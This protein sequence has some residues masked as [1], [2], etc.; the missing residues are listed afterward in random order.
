MGSQETALR[1]HEFRKEEGCPIIPPYGSIP[2]GDLPPNL[3]FVAM[4]A[5]PWRVC[6][7]MAAANCDEMLSAASVAVDPEG[8]ERIVRGAIS[9]ATNETKTTAYIDDGLLSEIA[10]DTES[11]QPVI[12]E[13]GSPLDLPLVFASASLRG[14]GFVPLNLDNTGRIKFAGF[15]DDPVNETMVRAGFECVTRSA[16]GGCPL[17]F[18]RDRKAS[19]AGHVRYLRGIVDQGGLGSLWEKLERLRTF[20]ALHGTARTTY[21][22]LDGEDP[23]VR[24][25]IEEVAVTSSKSGRIPAQPKGLVANIAE[26]Y[27]DLSSHILTGRKAHDSQAIDLAE[28]KVR[29]L[30]AQL[31]YEQAID[32]YLKDVDVHTGSDEMR[33]NRLGLIA[34]VVNLFARVGDFDALLENGREDLIQAKREYE[35]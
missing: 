30:P 5:K 16:L 11:P 34:S 19:L 13:V 20:P 3:F 29:P 27:D 35:P 32:R 14:V 26:R 12:S 1:L 21:T 17:L 2:S 24:T 22:L 4:G 31:D 8:C 7:G 33:N 10:H 15:A 6:Q 28:E 18:S 9:F 25:A 23:R